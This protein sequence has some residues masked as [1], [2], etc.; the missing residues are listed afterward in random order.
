VKISPHL[1]K[2]ARV[3]KD[4]A[5]VEL[6]ID[7][8]RRLG[9]WENLYLYQQVSIIYQLQNQVSENILNINF[10]D[11]LIKKRHVIIAIKV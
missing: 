11:R 5:E 7:I 9:G 1:W 2:K 3:K 8:K 6:A 4:P 10:D